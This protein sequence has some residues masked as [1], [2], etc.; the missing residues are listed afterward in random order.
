ME[1]ENKFD[2]LGPFIILRKLGSGLTSDIYLGFDKERNLYRALKVLKEKYSKE[3][4]KTLKAEVNILKDLE[5]PGIIK[6]FD[7][8][9]NQI[10]KKASGEKKI[11]TYIELEFAE[12]G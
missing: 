1:I 8:K 11:V 10:L 2:I 7:V 4:S 3:T 9:L 5:F 6:I 12:C